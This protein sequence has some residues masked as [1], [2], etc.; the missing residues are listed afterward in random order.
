ML[1]A[2]VL[3]VALCA[4]AATLRVPK[5]TFS[6]Q[7][8]SPHRKVSSAHSARPGT[9]EELWA[10][11][12]NVE[13]C[14]AIKW[15]DTVRAHY[16]AQPKNIKSMIGN[17]ELHSGDIASTLAVI[18]RLDCGR[19]RALDVAAGIGRVTKFILQHHFEKTDLIDQ[20]EELLRVARMD[21]DSSKVGEFIAQP[22]QSVQLQHKYDLVVMQ[23][24][25]MY[26][27]DV[28]LMDLLRKLR[29]ALRPGGYVL[30]RD[31]VGEKQSDFTASEF[32][33]ARTAFHY[34]ALINATALE[35]AQAL[36]PDVWSGYERVIT[37]VLR[38]VER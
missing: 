28:D 3:H 36:D 14:D 10:S 20:D 27:T 31:N 11:V 12:V 6:S 7:L 24:I 32:C 21:L 9:V 8:A 37:F 26:L 25:S 22:V 33:V 38:K 5:G 15:Y 29:D 19:E 23:W 2:L 18:E 17:D 16:A 34:G 4:P 13:L 1:M 30:L 35:I